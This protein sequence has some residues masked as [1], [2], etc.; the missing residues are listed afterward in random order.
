[1]IGLWR[2]LQINK[3]F[4]SGE[5]DF[6]FKNATLN[7]VGPSGLGIS[8]STTFYGT[9]D[10]MLFTLTVAKSSVQLYPVGSVVEFWFAFDGSSPETRF[11]MV[12]SGSAGGKDPTYWATAAS[13]EGGLS[14]R[15]IE[16]LVLTS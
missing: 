3:G 6:E 7:A 15:L 9:S 2:G 11:L 5:W 4:Q 14:W 16:C 10:R 1:L 13:S 8:G 12:A